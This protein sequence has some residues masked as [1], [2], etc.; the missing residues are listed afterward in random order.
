MNLLLDT[1]LLIWYLEGDKRL[2]SGAKKAI[3]DAPM[4]FVSAASILEI[5]IKSM[6]GKLHAP[7]NLTASAQQKGFQLLPISAEAAETLATLPQL[8]RHDPFD[9]LLLAQASIEKLILL[10]TDAVL[11]DLGLPFVLDAR[12]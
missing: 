1:Q 6:L 11:I 3:T 4:V 2:P 10:T 9:R 7:A 8:T 5:T 12:L